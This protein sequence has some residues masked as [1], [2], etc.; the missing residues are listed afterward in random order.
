MAK[1][2]ARSREKDLGAQPTRVWF[3]VAHALR[4]GARAHQRH[5]RRVHYRRATHGRRPTR[6]RRRIRCVR[7]RMRGPHVRPAALWRLRTRMPNV[8]P[9]CRRSVRV[10]GRTR[11]LRGKV[12]GHHGR[13]RALRRLRRGVRR[14]S[15]LRRRRLRGVWRGG[16]TVLR[17]RLRR[18]CV[19]RLRRRGR[20]A[21]VRSAVV[22]RA[23]PRPSS[24]GLGD[25]PMQSRHRGVRRQRRRGVG[26]LASR[27]DTAG[28]RCRLSGV[29]RV[30]VARLR[31][32][33]L[34]LRPASGSV[35][36]LPG[37]ELRR[38]AVHGLHYGGNR[39]RELH[40]EPRYVLRPTRARTPC[41]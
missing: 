16:P 31:S 37:R 4:I 28:Q 9:V 5:P 12:C 29:R 18:P 40:L 41:G 39:P 11:A 24:G 23:A 8:R 3:P 7:S 15:G 20:S 26:V 10:R 30:P 2:D 19:D 27:H 35:S 34:R 1:G 13:P 17:R 6:L 14:P 21:H 32:G 25:T 36:V 33:H 22:R 38:R